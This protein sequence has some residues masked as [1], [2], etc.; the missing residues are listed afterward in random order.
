MRIRDPAKIVSGTEITEHLRPQS[1]LGGTDEMGFAY[2]DPD[3]GCAIVESI[4][5]QKQVALPEAFDELADE[6]MLR[7][8]RLAENEAQGRAADQVEQTAE[9]DGNRAQSLLA[10]VPAESLP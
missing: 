8:G 9:F 1:A 10:L 2:Q 3:E 6:L 7:S 4:I 5:Q